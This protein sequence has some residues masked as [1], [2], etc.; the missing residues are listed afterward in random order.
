MIRSFGIRALSVFVTLMVA[1][2]ALVDL[3]T[4]VLVQPP[5]AGQTFA[6]VAAHHIHTFRVQVTVVSIHVSLL[7]ALVDV[8][9][10]DV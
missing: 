8:C 2:R 5:E 4:V 7:G 10:C 1:G 3:H 6:D 9:V